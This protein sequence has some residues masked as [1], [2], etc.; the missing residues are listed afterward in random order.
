[1]KKVVFI[2][3]GSICVLLGAI[4]ILVPGLPTTPFMLLAAWFYFRSSDKLY[5]KLINNKLLGKY[6]C[7]YEKNKA[8]SLRTKI[9]SIA[10]MWIMIAVSVIFLINS[11]IL[12]IIVSLVG[13][14]GTVVMGFVIKTFK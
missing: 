2:I 10:I 13:I 5:Q 7:R 12:K 14:I 8:I 11:D 9:Y 1:M 3:L 6:I 4:G